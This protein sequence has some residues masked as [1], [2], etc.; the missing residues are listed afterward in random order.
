[1]VDA[2]KP[3]IATGGHLLNTLRAHK[4][5]LDRRTKVKKSG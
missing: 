4:R 5:L 2:L 3:K 1:V